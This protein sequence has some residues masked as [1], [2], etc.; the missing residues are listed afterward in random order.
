MDI[1]CRFMS[2][3]FPD[4]IAS[5]ARRGLVFE[6]SS[7]H[8]Y[9]FSDIVDPDNGR[10]LFTIEHEVRSMTHPLFMRPLVN[11]DPAQNIMELPARPRR[12]D[13]KRLGK[14]ASGDE[15]A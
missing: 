13:L 10:P 2:P 3:I 12:L 6:E 4:R 9:R 11:R 15:S 14:G 5:S 7:Q 8:Q 1:M